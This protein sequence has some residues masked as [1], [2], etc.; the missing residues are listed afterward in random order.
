MV[1][2]TCIKCGRIIPASMGSRCE[3]HPKRW[4]SGSTREWRTT[5][6]RILARDG[7]RCTVQVRPGER[8]EGTKL[9]EIHHRDGGGDVLLVPDEELRTVCRKHNP[10]GG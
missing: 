7:Y 8:C 4:R 2:R 5:R 1:M 10:R 6:E 9:L 3:L